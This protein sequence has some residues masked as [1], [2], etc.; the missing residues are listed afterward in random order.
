MKDDGRIPGLNMSPYQVS[1]LYFISFDQKM[2]KQIMNNNKFIKTLNDEL[3]FCLLSV[4]RYV[5]TT[6]LWRYLTTV[7]TC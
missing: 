5:K 2:F 6:V 4:C 3:E 1:D 7:S